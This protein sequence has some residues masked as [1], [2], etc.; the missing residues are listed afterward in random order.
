MAKEGLAV[1]LLS[2][3]KILDVK[4]PDGCVMISYDK[5]SNIIMKD[6]NN[7]ITSFNTGSTLEDLS[8]LTISNP[9]DGQFLKY[10]GGTWVNSIVPGGFTK[11]EQLED[12]NLSSLTT[13]QTITYD[14]N[15]WIN[16]TLSTSGETY[17]N[18]GGTVIQ[19]GGIPTGTTFNNITF[20]QF[21][22]MTCYPE[23]FGTLTNP[24][25]TFTMSTSGYRE[26]GEIISTITFSSTFNRG[27][28][29][30]QYESTS[31]YRS[32]LPNT[33]IYTGTNLINYSSTSLTDSQTINNY[34]VLNGTQSWTGAVKYDAGLQPK[35][36]KGTSFNI[37]LISGQTST[38]T[39]SIVGVYPYYGTTSTITT[40]TKQTLTSMSSSYVEL[41]MVAESGVNKQKAEFPTTWSTITGVQFFNTV[42]NAWEWIN[43][44]KSNSLTT[45]TISGTTE[46]IQGNVINYNLWINNSA[47]IGARLLR[48]YTT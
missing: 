28:I 8:D 43:G 7:N 40:L 23:L 35:G 12:V 27:S 24:S 39:R 21:V 37:P 48:F 33:Y 15:K 16:S 44:S 31:A 5:N 25:S 20:S 45:F 19:I 17:T 29:N 13:G 18:T 11:F 4:V 6:S 36:S 34:N 26:I 22:D 9:I 32:G 10:S 38:V 46:T 47:L 42:S 41:S 3:E 1:F 30:P 14:G 2:Y